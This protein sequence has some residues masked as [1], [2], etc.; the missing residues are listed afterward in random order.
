MA[1][2]T[3]GWPHDLLTLDDWESLDIGEGHHV[4]C[5]EGIL[6]VAPR[7]HARHQK[8]L[9]QLANGL[10][11]QLPVNLTTVAEVEV[12]LAADPLTVRVPDL[13]VTRTTVYEE[14]PSRF[15]AEEVLLIV[16]II[17]RGSRRTDRVTK[18]NEYAEAGIGEYWIL[19]GDPLTLSAYALQADGAYRL[20]GDFRGQTSLM[21]CGTPIRLDLEALTRR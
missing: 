11:R 7:P 4:E 3:T 21:A 20:T 14:N 8:A 10:D 18:M 5:V 2:A 9:I 19:D 1:E 13:I 17:S 12:L 16:E 6:I 15:K